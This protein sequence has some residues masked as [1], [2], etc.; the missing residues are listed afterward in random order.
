MLIGRVVFRQR[1]GPPPVRGA[2]LVAGPV[3]PVVCASTS[4][5]QVLGGVSAIVEK[6]CG[7][8]WEGQG[9]LSLEERVRRSFDT[10]PAGREDAKRYL[11]AVRAA[12]REAETSLSRTLGLLVGVL[13]AFYLVGSGDT[14]EVSLRLV[15]V[16]NLSVVMLL[17]T[18]V[19]AW[20][21]ASFIHLATE[22]LC[23]GEMSQVLTRHV[24][25]AVHDSDL[26]CYTWPTNSYIY[27][28]RR[29]IVRGGEFRGVNRLLF[30]LSLARL[31]AVAATPLLI[32]PYMIWFLYTATELHAAL[33]TATAAF[34]VIL[35]VS[36][37]VALLGYINHTGPREELPQS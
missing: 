30:W 14:E 5:R 8:V 9:V 15:T 28:T 29:F 12:W 21:H 17:F 10:S 24:D 7:R 23:L 35:F 25:R 27:S 34:V 33:V 18:L 19:L 31:L 13:A 6:H 22:S 4:R 20:L 11:E 37:W 1:G 2:P 3:A 36:G 32:E 16:T 26:D